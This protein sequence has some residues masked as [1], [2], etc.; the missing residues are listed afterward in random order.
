MKFRNVVIS[1]DCF[2]N[3]LPYYSIIISLS[4]KCDNSKFDYFSCVDDY[5]EYLILIEFFGNVEISSF[6]LC[7]DTIY[8]NFNLDNDLFNQFKSFLEGSCA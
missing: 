3:L 5:D 1:S 2:E 8:I 6:K 7:D 4:T